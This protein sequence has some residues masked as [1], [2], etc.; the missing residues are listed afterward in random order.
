LQYSGEK[1]WYNAY[2]QAQR[3]DDVSEYLTENCVFPDIELDILVL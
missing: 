3:S 1:N 2:G